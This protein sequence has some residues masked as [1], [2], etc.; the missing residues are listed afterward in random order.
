MSDKE[1]NPSKYP[2][3]EIKLKA[4]KALVKMNAIGLFYLHVPD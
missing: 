2:F 4:M 3:L 1:V